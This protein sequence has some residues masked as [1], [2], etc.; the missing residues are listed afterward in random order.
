MRMSAK[1]KGVD[2]FFCPIAGCSVITFTG[3]LCPGCTNEGSHIRG[4]TTERLGMTSVR[5]EG[6]S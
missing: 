5:Q 4:P 2:L 1:T 6:G 3:K